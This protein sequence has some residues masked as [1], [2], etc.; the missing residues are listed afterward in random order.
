MLAPLIS[1]VGEFG[2]TKT[3]KA[4]GNKR[5]PWHWDEVHQRAFDHIKA[6]ITK[7]TVLAYPDYWKVFKI[8][9]DAS[10]KGLG[11]VIMQDN[12]PIAFF[13]WKLSNTQHK[14]SDT[15]IE[16]LAIVETLNEFKW[17]L[18]GQNMKVC[19]DHANIMRDTLG[20]T[21]DRVYQWR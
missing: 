16:P 1:L 11:A 19:T 9:T 15:E 2:Q 21:L 12:W 18:R 5:V 17:M 8:Y 7:Y 20:S 4:K 10:I 14:Y 13:S 3:T 6:T